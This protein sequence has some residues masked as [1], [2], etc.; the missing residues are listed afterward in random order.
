MKNG[1]KD[2]PEVLQTTEQYK[3]EDDFYND[4]VKSYIIKSDDKSY[5][6]WTDLKSDFEYWYN[7]NY[8]K[9][10]PKMKETKQY[11]EKKVFDKE[12]KQYM[13]DSEKNLKIR[14][15]IGYKCTYDRDVDA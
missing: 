5:I 11:F 12:E 15:W 4:F 8:H 9:T 14:G 3:H 6:K 7:S 10:P 2:I 13:I 1:L